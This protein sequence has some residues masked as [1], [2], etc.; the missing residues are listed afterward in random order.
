MA[1]VIAGQ[2]GSLDG[3]ATDGQGGSA[4]LAAALRDVH[5]PPPSL[6]D[7]VRVGSA[8]QPGGVKPVVVAGI[9]GEWWS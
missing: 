7:G 2:T 8:V 6:V 5:L 3:F 9:L 1:R 4:A